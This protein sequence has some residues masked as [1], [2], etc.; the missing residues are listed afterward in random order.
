MYNEKIEA[1]IKAA[2][3]DGELTEKEKQILFKKAQE[4]GIDLD[5]F[6]MVL[7][8]KLFELKKTNQPATHSAPKSDKFGD[9]RKCPACGAIMKSFQTKCTDCGHEFSNVDSVQSANKLFDLLQACE[10]RKSQE[11]SAHDVEKNRRLE[12]L[13]K[14]QKEGDS[15][16][17]KIFSGSN[18]KERDDEE[19]EDLIR[20]LNRQ[21][22]DIEK[23][24]TV[25]KA[26]IIKTYPV[27]NSKEDLLEMLAMATSSAYDND[28]H[29]GPEEEVWIQKTD[30]IY[31][32][33]II[34]AAGDRVIL[35]QAT[36]MIVSLMRR[37]PERYKN[38]TQIPKE[39]QAK[40]KEDIK[41]A[42]KA[43][44]DEKKD[45][46]INLIKG[47]RGIAI[48]VCLLIMLIGFAVDGGIAFLGFIGCIVFIV[49]LVKKYKSE[50]VEIKIY[51]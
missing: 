18:R 9:V 22:R 51:Q 19:R 11:L 36:N 30:Q 43:A 2:L 14:I 23:K 33:I 27:P 31:Q 46:L 3:A 26:H 13:A 35:D 17:A 15:S 8:A 10:L 16:L 4:E 40:L 20:E 28:G 50:T 5:E 41:A 47:W 12:Q 49:L 42:K 45:V 37:L 34:C 32:K 1:L 21:A 38:F 39:V 29:I 48:G 25:E 7:D 24:Y 44:N 6:E